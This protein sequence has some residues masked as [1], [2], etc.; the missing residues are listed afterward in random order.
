MDEHFLAVAKAAGAEWGDWDFYHGI[1]D[2]APFLLRQTASEPPG[3]YFKFRLKGKLG[4]PAPVARPV[5][6]TR[7][8]PASSAATPPLPEWHDGLSEDRAKAAVS[9]EIDDEYVFLWIGKPQLLPPEDIASLAREC[10]QQH[11]SI[12]PDQGGLCLTCGSVGEGELFQSE[13][14]VTMICPS[15]LDKKLENHSEA[16]EEL[17]RPSGKLPLLFPAALL[18]GGILW[19]V[20]WDLWETVLRLS[21]TNEIK[22]PHLV[23]IVAAVGFGYCAGWPIGT[24]LR[25][26]GA[27]SRV[28]AGIVAILATLTIVVIG[29]LLFGL[30]LSYSISGTIDVGLALQATLPFALASNPK[31]A[32]IKVLF[33]GTLAVAAYEVSKPTTKKLRL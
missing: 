13:A 6:V 17:N 15:C 7:P 12:L 4:R 31:Y 32:L 5:A 25:R 27:I 16:L 30:A 19:A 24:V 21:Q 8:S 29:E 10:V 28:A 18:A 20:A 26:S 33:A 9:C 23:L 2:G 11:A 1:L 22:I 14:S 3:C